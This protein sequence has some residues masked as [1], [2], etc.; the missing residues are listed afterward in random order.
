MVG[1]SSAMMYYRFHE[2]RYSGGVMM[3][4]MST[5]P[6]LRQTPAGV[7]LD[8]CGRERFVKV[9]ARKRFACPTEEE[10]LQSFHARKRRQVRIL[11]YQLAS[12]EAALRL[13][14]DGETSPVDLV[15]EI[16]K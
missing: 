1:T 16:A 12:A 11:R 14:K 10:A 6:V 8:V 13:Q 2:T 3:L 4:L 9:D 7:W 5:F 15:W